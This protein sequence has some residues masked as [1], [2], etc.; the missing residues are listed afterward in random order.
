MESPCGMGIGRKSPSQDLMAMGNS[1]PRGDKDG[2]TFTTTKVNY[3]GRSRASVGVAAPA[4]LP[5][6]FLQRVPL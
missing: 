6:V 2:E 4:A 3:R 5:R 1:L